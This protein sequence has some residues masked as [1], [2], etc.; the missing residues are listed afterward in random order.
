MRLGFLIILFIFFQAHLFSQEVLDSSIVHHEKVIY[1]NS[2]E[3][4]LSE[5]DKAEIL[6]L[7]EVKDGFESYQF[8]VDAH[9]DDVGSDTYNQKL[10]ERRKESI[11][12]YL[13]AHQI[14]DT[15]VISNFHGESLRVALSDD[16]ESRR[17]NRR[18][19]VQ[20]ITKKKFVY[21]KGVILDEETKEA[22]S[23]DIQLNTKTFS[24]TTK[25]DSTGKFKILSPTDTYVS[26]EVVAKDYFIETNTLKV[27]EAYAGKFLKVPMPKIEIGKKFTFK[28]MLFVGNKSIV[29]PGSKR[30]L[31]HLKRFMFVNTEQCIEI[32]GHINRPNN[33]RVEKHTVNYQL[34]VARALEVHDAL[35]RIGIDED[36]ML[37]RGYGNWQMLFPFAKSEEKQRLNRRVEIVISD[38]D[39]TKTILNHAIP[40]RED[41]NLP[42]PGERQYSELH[43]ERDIKKFSS[44]AQNDIKAQIKKFKK[45]GRDATQYTYREMLKAF[46]DLPK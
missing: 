17:L 25:T 19:V 35:Q 22:I 18:A 28:N 42:N 41:F 13:K 32:A 23:A 38:C 34:S 15:S 43:L 40:N 29:L 44:K 24:S 26:I 45:K 4:A 30:V 31:E 37:A 14:A 3:H 39:S 8:Y 27:T 36:R 7:I 11:V 20:L 9:T 21:L 6:E 2:D 1:F 12:S 46:P 33:G 10:S 16:K 5:G